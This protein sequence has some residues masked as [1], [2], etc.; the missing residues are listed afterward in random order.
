MICSLLEAELE[1]SHRLSP[2]QERKLQLGR[3]GAAVVVAREHE[4]EQRVGGLV[5]GLGGLFGV[6]GVGVAARE[7]VDGGLEPVR[8]PVELVDVAE[9]AVE[10]LEESMR[11]RGGVWEGEVLEGAGVGLGRGAEEEGGVFVD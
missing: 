7:I 4:P 11:W 10:V 6:D 5:D 1:P 3:L 2:A 9:G 8:V